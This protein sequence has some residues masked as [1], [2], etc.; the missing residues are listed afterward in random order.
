MEIAFEFHSKLAKKCLDE[1]DEVELETETRVSKKSRLYGADRYGQLIVWVFLDPWIEEF[2]PEL[3][4]VISKY[5]KIIKA[6]SKGV[7]E[8]FFSFSIEKLANIY[9]KCYGKF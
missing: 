7:I 5:S 4:D 8:T 9:G 1:D 6:H 2:F 3:W